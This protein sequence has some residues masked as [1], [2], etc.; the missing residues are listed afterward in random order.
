MRAWVIAIILVFFVANVPSA[1]GQS[2]SAAVPEVP[3]AQLVERAERRWAE[4]LVSK[5]AQELATALEQRFRLI[6][7]G[8]GSLDLG[9]DGYLRQQGRR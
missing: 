2:T 4:A 9:R 1:A 7:V 3:S 5:D 8:A 6:T